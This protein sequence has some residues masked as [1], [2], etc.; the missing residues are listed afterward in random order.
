MEYKCPVSFGQATGRED[1]GGRRTTSASP[2]PPVR[3]IMPC[4]RSLIA[5]LV[6]SHLSIAAPSAAAAVYSNQWYVCC[7]FSCL[8]RNLLLLSLVVSEVVDRLPPRIN[9]ATVLALSQ[10]C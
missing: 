6:L 3:P 8:P 1:E 9:T 2:P 10:T 4:A 7:A 5:V